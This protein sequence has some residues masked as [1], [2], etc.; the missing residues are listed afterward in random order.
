MD[1]KNYI[2]DLLQ[3]HKDR[4][5]LSAKEINEYLGKASNGGGT[6]SSIAGIR[7]KKLQEPTKRDWKLLDKLDKINPYI[8]IFFLRDL[9]G[10]EII[11]HYSKII[12]FLK[13]T[14]FDDIFYHL[15]W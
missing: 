11:Q 1:S 5:D 2:R 14:K 13:N 7:Q 15:I 9:C 8:F 3:S 12:T 10:Y 4:L 6:W